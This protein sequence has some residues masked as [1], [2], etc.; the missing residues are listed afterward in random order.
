MWLDP[1]SRFREFGFAVIPAQSLSSRRRGR[2]SRFPLAERPS[3]DLC[4]RRS[5]S[6]GGGNSVCLLQNG[7]LRFITCAKKIKTGVFT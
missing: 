7:R 2:E 3:T 5:H 4:R 1:F 6:H